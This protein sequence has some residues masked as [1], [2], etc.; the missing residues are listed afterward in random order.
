M[1]A[2]AGPSFHQPNQTIA[3]MI[4]VTNCVVGSTW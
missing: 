1:G 3:R 2:H 4:E